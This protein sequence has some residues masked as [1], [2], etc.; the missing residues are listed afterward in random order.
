[1][2]VPREFGAEPWEDP[3]LLWRYSP[4]AYAH[5]ITTPLLIIHSE[6]DF[7]APIPDAEQLFAIVRRNGQTVEFVRFPREGHELSRSGELK[8]R[9]ERLTRMVAWFDR[10]CKPE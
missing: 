6:S 4:L 1:M 2:L 9:I 10:Y 8:H 7:R 5:N 3:E